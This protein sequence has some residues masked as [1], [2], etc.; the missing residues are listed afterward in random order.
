MIAF[1]PRMILAAAIA[2]VILTPVQAAES[3]AEAFT[4]G[5]T[6][7]SFRLRYEDVNDDA[8]EDAEALTLKSR[9][10]FTTDSYKGFSA[11]LEVDDVTELDNVT[12]TDGVTNRG[13]TPI[14]DPEDTDVNQ[15]YLAYTT[16]ATTVK[17][18]RQRILLDNQRFVGGVGFRQN[19]QTYDALSITNTSLPDTTLFYS[20]ISSVNG[21]TGTDVEHETHLVNAKYT[22]L[23]IG[24]LSAY[25]Y[26]IEL[27]DADDSLDTYG[28][29]LSGSKPAGDA[30]ILYTA[31]Y[32]TQENVGGTAEPDYY[33]VEGGVSVAGVT[34]K[35]GYEV[36]GSD[37]GVGFNTPLATKH[38]FQGWADMFLAT[39]GAGIEDLYFSVGTTLAGIKLLAVYHDYESDEGS[40]DFGDEWGFLAA[41]SF[42]KN[43]G[44]ELKYA[45]Y[46]AGK[47]IAKED[48][49][50]LWLTATAKF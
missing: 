25:Y 5:K 4:N 19:E 41:K 33:V 2:S 45:S 8:A 23:P 37:E 35:L 46:D 22:G 6:N 17:V 32:A 29:R 36:L 10:T 12:Y 9:I 50:K 47:D 40:L 20:Y 15:A 44:L 34:A 24:A 26:S 14:V 31:E 49:S 11:L 1:P 3:I 27:E 13:T 21:I 28:V 43:Y 7:V 39:P 42:G 38:K 16:G 48:K 30:K 18:G